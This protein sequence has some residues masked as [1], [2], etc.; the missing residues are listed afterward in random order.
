MEE[1]TLLEKFRFV[2]WLRTDDK[3]G[4][5]PNFKVICPNCD[6]EE[7]FLRNSELNLVRVNSY[8]RGK[9]SPVL[10]VMYKCIP[11]AAVMWF[12][13]GPPQGMDSDYW[14]EILKRRDNHPLY[15][16]PVEEWSEDAK[17]QQRLKDLGYLGGDVEIEE[18]TETEENSVD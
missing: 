5:K 4:F 11:C 3:K 13:V 10:Q 8:G 12:H 6:G 18:M 15:V 17:I 16:P 7:M 1:V 9:V 2:K 14:N